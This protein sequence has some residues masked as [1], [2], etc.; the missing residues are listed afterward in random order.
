MTIFCKTCT[1][2][3]DDHSE[4][5]NKD[6]SIHDAFCVGIDGKTSNQVK[7]EPD[8]ITMTLNVTCRCMKFEPAT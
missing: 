7:G 3:V 4:I 5:R 2:S 1:H 8:G 6:G